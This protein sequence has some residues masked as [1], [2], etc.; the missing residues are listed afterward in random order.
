MLDSKATGL[1]PIEGYLDWIGFVIVLQIDRMSDY[2]FEVFDSLLDLLFIFFTSFV[3]YFEENQN[4]LSDLLNQGSTLIIR[5]LL[6]TALRLW[7][8]MIEI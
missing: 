4:F 7:I 3:G 6:G 5:W 1:W 8:R 2:L